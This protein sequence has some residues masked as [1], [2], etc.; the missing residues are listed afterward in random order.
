MVLSDGITVMWFDLAPIRERHPIPN[1]A[2]D[3]ARAKLVEVGK[4]RDRAQRRR[5][6]LFEALEF[7]E[8][9]SEWTATVRR[10]DVSEDEN[11]VSE[12]D[13]QFAKRD[14]DG[15]RTQCAELK[16]D[17]DRCDAEES[18][19]KHAHPEMTEGMWREMFPFSYR[20]HTNFTLE[21]ISM[22]FH[23]P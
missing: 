15:L 2:W 14:P 18:A 16:A 22:N 11:D 6:D 12:E 4:R 10:S 5:E 20:R 8:V 1:D 13:F 17:A 23:A 9:N 3:T 19:I 21:P 7:A